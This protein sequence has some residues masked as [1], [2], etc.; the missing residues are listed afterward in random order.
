MRTVG[1]HL[2]LSRDDEDIIVESL[3]AYKSAFNNKHW[4]KPIPLKGEAILFIYNAFS[5]WLGIKSL[6]NNHMLDIW[7][8]NK[9]L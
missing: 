5:F 7:H 2:D 9:L 8:R 3:T 6:V 1:E 4:S